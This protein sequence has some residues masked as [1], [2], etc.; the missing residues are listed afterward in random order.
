ME[1][2]EI[3]LNSKMTIMMEETEIDLNSK[4]IIMMEKPEI[5]L[6]SK[7]TITMDEPEIDLKDLSDNMIHT[8]EPEIYLGNAYDGKAY[9]DT[10]I[11]VA[12]AEQPTTNVFDGE[13]PV[14][15]QVQLMTSV[16]SS[17]IPVA[18]AVQPMT[19]VLGSDA[20][21]RLRTLGFPQGLAEEM[22]NSR[23]SCPM[24][25]WIV[26][27]S[28]SMRL[29]DG[30]RIVT[31]K[32]NVHVVPCSRWLEL[33]GTIEYHAELAGLLK[34]PTVF[35]MLNDPGPT[36]G[37]QEFRVGWLI[38]AEVEQAKAI[39]QKDQPHG[40]TPLSEHVREIYQRIKR[41]EGLMRSQGQQAVVVIATD[42]FPSD[43]KGYS[44]SSVTEQ[45]VNDL[46]LLQTL[47]VCIVIRLCTD[48][49]SVVEFY[50]NLDSKLELPLEVLDDFFSEAQEIQKAN[51]WLNYGLP[52]H[53]SREMGYH[54]R[55]FD[56]LDEKLLSKDELLEVLLLLFGEE[57]LQ[58]APN[59]HRDWNGF[60]SFLS[61][62]VVKEGK[63][64]NPVTKK[65]DYWIDTR[66]LD[67]A[68]GQPRFWGLYC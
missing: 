11:P 58:N 24:R 50:N 14:A 46:R 33:Q 31:D 66:K 4:M 2:T 59:V 42:G 35:R 29:S 52:L 22:G 23:I 54:H 8:V 18:P 3:N 38:A 27:N 28:G 25:F 7:M 37:P 45:F 16:L 1:E 21:A 20:I 47:P 10:E 17:E 13:I 26:D 62:L 40:V 19:N 30:K 64:F 44:S 12:H 5:D 68:Y 48:D 32:N 36:V 65:M 49:N 41:M 43:G 34:F 60:L 56:S 63:I 61:S 55:I 53:R 9:L 39:I 6:N 51:P 57:Q 15:Q 67:K